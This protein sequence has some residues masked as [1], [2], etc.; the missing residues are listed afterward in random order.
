M[1][2]G[3]KWRNCQDGGLQNVSSARRPSPWAP[4]QSWGLGFGASGFNPKGARTQII[5]FRARINGKVFGP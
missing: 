4:D 2:A 1:A 3:P 5:G